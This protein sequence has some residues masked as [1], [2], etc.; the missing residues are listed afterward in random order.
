M[1]SFAFLIRLPVLTMLAAA[2]LVVSPAFAQVYDDVAFV[3]GTGDTAYAEYDDVGYNATDN[4]GDRDDDTPINEIADKMSNPL[5]QE[6]VANTVERMT[7]AMMNIPVGTFVGAIEDARPGTV[8]R[9]VARNS[10]VGDLAGR[11]AEYLPQELGERSR[12][13]MSMMGGFANAMAVMMPEFE[14][15]SREMEESFRV[16]KA[17]AKRN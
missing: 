3:A 1:R 2:P 14:R 5:I 9:G 12:D 7:A 13:M 11:D 17:Q 8:K 16:A 10:T 4:R 6:G 15:M